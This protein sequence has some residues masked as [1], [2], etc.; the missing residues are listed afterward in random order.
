VYA[1]SHGD[2]E[3]I[4]KARG[5]KTTFTH[6]GLLK[7]TIYPEPQSLKK[8]KLFVRNA[9]EYSIPLRA[10]KFLDSKWTRIT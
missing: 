3:R 7:R 9:F 5:G 2:Q 6:S 10:N 4:G 8:G 1:Y